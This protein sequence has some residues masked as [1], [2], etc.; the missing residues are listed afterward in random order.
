MNMNNVENASERRRQSLLTLAC[1]ACGTA[2]LIRWDRLDKLLRCH[3]CA[4]WFRLQREGELVIVPPPVLEEKPE[5]IRVEV[6]SCQSNWKAHD[7]PLPRDVE[8]PPRLAIRA[9]LRGLP[10]HWI[11]ACSVLLIGG[12]VTAALL[13]HRPVP[14]HLGELPVEL[15]PRARLLAE[16]WLAKDTAQM[17]RLTDAAQDRVLR[18]WLAD[19]PPPVADASSSSPPRIDVLIQPGGAQAADLTV[20]VSL[21]QASETV[22][23][24]HWEEKMG[25]WYF[26]PSV[27]HT[28]QRPQPVQSQQLA[29]P[30]GPKRKKPS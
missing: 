4:T 25:S 11:A 1:P 3:G 19:H 26:L 2:G 6:R 23:H 20:R 22:W 12:V 16:A 17:L 27:M 21:A 18:R 9:F 29:A 7:A 15:E 8:T 5:T 13:L 24:Q 30:S 28:S 14:P 10:L